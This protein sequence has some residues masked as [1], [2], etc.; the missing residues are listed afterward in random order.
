MNSCIDSKDKT[1]ASWVIAVL[2]SFMGSLPAGV[3]Y[4]LINDFWKEYDK[5][6]PMKCFVTYGYIGLCEI[7][8][9]ICFRYKYESGNEKEE[10]KKEELFVSE[11][12][13]EKEKHKAVGIDAINDVHIPME[14]DKTELDEG[15][16]LENK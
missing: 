2:S 4:G 16:E 13:K 9:A 5:K 7:L 3:T 14:V 10:D 15:A 1:K 12:D 11:K 8:I 6:F